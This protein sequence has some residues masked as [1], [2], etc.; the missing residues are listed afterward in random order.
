MANVELPANLTRAG[1]AAKGFVDEFKAFLLKHQVLGL[2][3]GVVIGGAIGK[4]VSGIVDDFIMPIIGV[5][6]PGGEWRTAQLV[7]S[8]NNA[9]KYGDFIGRVVDFVFI[10]FVV[11]LIVKNFI[12][13]APP[14]PAPATKACPQCLETVPQ[15]ARRCRACASEL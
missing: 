1:G 13:E 12:K 11:F 14:A 2:A 4:V 7:L 10:A 3:I 8:G 5:I 6:L 15:A 9:I